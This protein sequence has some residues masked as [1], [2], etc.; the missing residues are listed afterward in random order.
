MK[1]ILTLIA[2]TK[3]KL[4]ADHIKS[5]AN[6]CPYTSI[7]WLAA[8]KAVDLFFD[9]NNIYKYRSTIKEMMDKET[10]DFIIQ[11]ND[12]YRRKR[13]LCADMD[14]TLIEQECLDELAE[15]IGIGS[16]IS[17]ITERAMRGEL[18][19]NES[20]TQRVSLLKGTPVSVL[21]EVYKR[22]TLTSGALELIQTMSKHSAACILISG[23]FTFF[24]DPIAE[25]LGC[26]E[27][28]SN[29]FEIQD[30]RLTGQVIRPFVDDVR[31]EQILETES[32]KR[33]LDN[34]LVMAVGDGANDIP[35]LNKAGIGIAFKAKPATEEA[36]E[37]IIRYSDLSALLYIQG[38]TQERFI[39]NKNYE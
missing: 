9:D 4:N 12:E 29:S 26:A 37:H 35:M 10:I 21:S 36:V 13:L 1:Y 7:N 8:D 14:S 19:F 5:V 15:Y 34:K 6:I 11:P 16:E 20:L 22:L 39:N 30:D 32:K 24:A 38:Y 18:D 28:Y 2:G 31:K 17:A 3:Q 33:S 23:G 25:R 27:S